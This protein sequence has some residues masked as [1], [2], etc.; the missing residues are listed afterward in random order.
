MELSEVLALMDDHQ[1]N[2]VPV[3]RNGRIVGLLGREQLMRVLRTR[4]ELGV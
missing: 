3:V 4:L 1:V 2:Q